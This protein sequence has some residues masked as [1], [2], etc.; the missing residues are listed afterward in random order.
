[1]LELGLAVGGL[2]IGFVVGALVMRN[3]YKHFMTE[4]KKYKDLILNSK[5]SAEQKVVHIRN[6]LKV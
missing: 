4:E 3:N 1:M 6:L 2:V 5:L